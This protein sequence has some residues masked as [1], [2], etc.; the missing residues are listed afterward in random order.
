MINRVGDLTTFSARRVGDFF[1]FLG[2][3]RSRRREEKGGGGGGGRR[4]QEEGSEPTWF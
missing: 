4:R 3:R 1:C 2:R